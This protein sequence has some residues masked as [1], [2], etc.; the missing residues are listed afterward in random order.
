[1]SLTRRG[2]VAMRLT[3]RPCEKPSER[4]GP[5]ISVA[6]IVSQDGLPVSAMAMPDRRVS[7]TFFV[8]DWLERTQPT[9]H[10]VGRT[11]AKACR[12]AIEWELC[13][14]TGGNVLTIDLTGVETLDYTAADECFVQL[15]RRVQGGA[16]DQ[17]ALMLTGTTR[18]HEHT[19]TV[20]LERAGLVVL[21][22]HEEGPTI[23]G[24]LHP[25]LRAVF[26]VVV[27]CHPVTSRELADTGG[28][29]ISLAAT[30]LRTL[31]QMRLVHREAE[32]LPGGGKQ[33]VYWPVKGP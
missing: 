2:R 28:I 14:M 1:M 8:D 17:A 23:L 24:H 21:V 11:V 25:Y 3:P 12:A 33:Y 18:S 4:C 31:Y 22:Q 27:Q 32:G 20:A 16:D 15:I 5:C 7:R 10:L 29:R 19:L 6:S 13:S 30:T 9:M 26:A